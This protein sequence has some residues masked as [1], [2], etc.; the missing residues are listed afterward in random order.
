QRPVAGVTPLRAV[1]RVSA[2]SGTRVAGRAPPPAAGPR[3]R[4]PMPSSGR[5]TNPPDHLH[6]G[7]D[8]GPGLLDLDVVPA[9]VGEH[10]LAVRGELQQRGLLTD[11]HG[12]LVPP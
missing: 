7:L 5:S 4:P 11:M 1:G 9:L 12:I 10:L 8:R 2:A 6:D 3:P